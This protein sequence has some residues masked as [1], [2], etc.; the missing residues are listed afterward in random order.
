M[1]DPKVQ[2]ALNVG[3]Y[4]VGMSPNQQARRLFSPAISA[5]REAAEDEAP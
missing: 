1:G 4:L 5:R 2:G 3:A